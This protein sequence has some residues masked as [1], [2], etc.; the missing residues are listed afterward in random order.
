MNGKKQEPS[1]NGR[2]LTWSLPA[3]A[4]GVRYEVIY[5]AVVYPNVPSGTILSNSATAQAIISGTMVNVNAAANADVIVVQGALSD[6]SVITGRVFADIMKTGHFMRGD[7]GIGGVRVFMEDGTSATTDAEGRFSFPA[8][9]P[10]MHVLRID[11]TTL[12]DG[13]GGTFQ[14]LLHGVLD[15]GLMQDIEFAVKL[16]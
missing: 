7:R 13:A 6:R 8:A 4:S 11:R 9:R 15:D 10:G 14:R 1:I 12:P 5:A 3:L 16:P 2:V